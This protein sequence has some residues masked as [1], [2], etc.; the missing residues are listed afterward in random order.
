[1]A[2]TIVQP[3]N[4]ARGAP[5]YLPYL[6]AL[7]M[8]TAEP[9]F[10]MTAYPLQFYLISGATGTTGTFEMQVMGRNQHAIA[11]TGANGASFAGTVLV[12]GTL[13]GANWITL[14]SIMAAGI[15]QYTGLY[16]SIR[17]SVADYTS[18]SITVAGITQRS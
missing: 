14:D 18:G 7:A 15:K 9:Q 6:P 5:K 1:M 11:V 10:Y 3:S 8:Q 12:E 17:V 2:N 13:D 16:R 4:I